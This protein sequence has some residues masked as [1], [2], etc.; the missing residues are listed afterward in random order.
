ML[1]S[2]FIDFGIEYWFR[3]RITEPGN[4][5]DI[6]AAEI[7]SI[8]WLIGGDAWTQLHD[9]WMENTA[10]STIFGNTLQFLA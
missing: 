9:K 7:W 5:S 4:T 1:W 3:F 2:C 6:G 8:D 10:I